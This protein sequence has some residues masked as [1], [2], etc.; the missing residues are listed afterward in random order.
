MKTLKEL[1]LQESLIGNIKDKN[2]ALAGVK[3]LNLY[4]ELIYQCI[5]L[6]EEY[7]VNARPTDIIILDNQKVLFYYPKRPRRGV[8]QLIID[9]GLWDTYKFPKYIGITNFKS[10]IAIKPDELVLIGLKNSKNKDIEGFTF[11]SGISPNHQFTFYIESKNSTPKLKNC[12]FKNISEFNV[13]DKLYMDLSSISVN[14][15]S[16]LVEKDKKSG[17]YYIDWYNNDVFKVLDNNNTFSSDGT[18]IISV[19]V[20]FKH[21]KDDN[22]TYTTIKRLLGENYKLGT[23]NNKSDIL[24]NFWE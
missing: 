12:T 16:N 21:V 13:V 4:K 7:D 11:D 6:P 20:N 15:Y 2:K 3:D 14:S 18:S 10:K 17:E 24:V 8:Y 1:L 5:Q 19:L 22:I 23:T 9:T